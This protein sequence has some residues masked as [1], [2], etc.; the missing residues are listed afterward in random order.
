MDTIQEKSL[1]TI[2]QVSII[3]KQLATVNTDMGEINSK[4]QNMDNRMGTLETRVNRGVASAAALSALRMQ[5]TVDDSRSQF[6]VGMGFYKGEQSVAIG[7]G[8]QANDNLAVSV[9]LASSNGGD[10]VA[11]CGLSWKLGKKTTSTIS[12]S[13]YQELQTELASIKDIV[14]QQQA[15]IEKLR[16]Q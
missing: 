14:A 1:D 16:N 13:Q 4:F 12:K 5:P 7:W 15:L 11:N 9:G 3:N 10:T 2:N 6:M 8:T